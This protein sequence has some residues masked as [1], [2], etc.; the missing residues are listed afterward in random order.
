MDLMLLGM[1][2]S[3]NREFYL[4]TCDACFYQKKCFK[5]E[6]PGQRSSDCRAAGRKVNL[7]LR[8]DEFDKDGETN[9]NDEDVDAKICHPEREEYATK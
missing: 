4:L 7:T 9:N 6:V 5:C 8:D 1:D 2:L 3:V